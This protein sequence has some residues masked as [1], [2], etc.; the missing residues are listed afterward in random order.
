M[1]AILIR[2]KDSE[3]KLLKKVKV[4]CAKRETTITDYVKD[5]IIKDIN[6]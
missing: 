5:L 1:K 2:F 3:Q 6:N 4:N